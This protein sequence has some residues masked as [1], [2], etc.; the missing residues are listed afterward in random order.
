MAI[1]KY[2]CPPQSA[3]GTGTFSDDLVGFQLVQGGGLTQ[4]NF[5]F[6]ESITEKVNR[7][8]STGIFSDPINLQG[9]GI[10]TVE[11]S[12][13]IFENNFKVYPNFD[14][15]QVTNF[16]QYGSLVK[17]LS[18]SV[19]KIINYFPGAIESLLFGIDF[20]TGATATNII[21]NQADNETNFELNLEKIR[22]PFDIDFSINAT[23]NLSL[24][25]IDV[26]Y[27][28]NLT[29]NF[30]KYS[31]Y[32]N[33][34]GYSL[35]RIVPTISLTNGILKIYVKGNPFSGETVTYQ[36]LIIRPND[37]EVNKVFNETLDEVENFLL[38]RNVTPKY[39]TTFKIPSITDDG[40]Y[41]I[42]HHQ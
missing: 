31:L 35:T 42:S 39:T 16:T 12:K 6:T 14:L 30:N 18:S 25:E 4:G 24:R 2:T 8:F 28:R 21:F 15:S 29:V 38:N 23:R 1:K 5:E 37:F 19:T 22:N 36:N 27:L 13:A 32:I 34:E 10:D 3:T 41:Y 40:Q 20:T 17:R 26:S 7:T 9:L 11:Q 33:D